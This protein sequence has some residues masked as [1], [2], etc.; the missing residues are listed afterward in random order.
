VHI[1]VLG[2]VILA[3]LGVCVLAVILALLLPH[4]LWSAPVLEIRE[5]FYSLPSSPYPCSCGEPAYPK[6]SLYA[7]PPPSWC[8][9]PEL[10]SPR[11]SGLVT[12]L[13]RETVRKGV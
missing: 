2:G 4:I 10:I 13:G 12:Q 6:G 7:S 5:W 9:S 1:D 11:R 8:G 3:A